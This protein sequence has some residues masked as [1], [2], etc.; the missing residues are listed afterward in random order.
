MKRF[1]LGVAAGSTVL[2]TYVTS[3]VSPST[4]LRTGQPQAP[5]GA[6][7]YKEFCGRC[8][9]TPQGRTP[10]LDALKAQS[11]RAILD[12]LNGGSMALQAQTLGPAEKARVAEY[13]AGRPLDPNT[14]TPSAGQCATRPDALPDPSTMPRW[15]G[16]GNDPTNARLQRDPGLTAADVPKLAVKW[17]FGFP[18]GAQAYGH[19]AIAAGRVFVGSDIGRVYALDAASGCTYWSFAADGGVRSAVSIGAIRDGNG[20][21]HA[22]YFGD[23][24]A[25]VYAVDAATGA[26]VWKTKVD[27]HRFARITGAPALHAGTLYIPVSSTEEGPGAQPA[28]PCCTF[29]GSIVALDA[30]TGSRIWKTY[31][32]PEEPKEV[33]KNAAGTPL[34]K[35]AGAAVWSSPTIDIARGVIYIGT[36]NAYT[37]PAAKTSDAVVALDMQKGTVVWVNQITPADAFVIGCRPENP[38]CPKEVGPDHDFGNAPIL[39]TLDGGKRII[40]IGQKSGVAYG[41]DPDRQGQIVWQF[42]AGKG[43]ALGGIEWGSA[44]DERAA[45]IPVSDVLLPPNEAG[46]LFALNLADGERLW[47]TPAPKLTCTSGRGCSGAQSAPISV[48]PGVVFSGSIDGHIRAYS[49]ADGTIIWDFNTA[50]EFETVNQVPAKGGSIDAAGPVIAGGLLI[51]NSGYG[52]WRGM[53]GNVLLAFSAK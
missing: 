2:T 36:G 43:S 46:G 40:V 45:Y 3:S 39:R 22:A 31:M 24:K 38:N 42:R 51:T 37:E 35:P 14:S 53:P 21:R 8:H 26:L 18:G 5:D 34:W 27:D 47:H 23:L 41:L 49:T 44:A 28:Y 50:R 10:A 11:A 52:L 19:P 48:I 15:S 20:P 4:S 17:A 1:L 16:W 32:I 12:A 6:A 33:G 30:A 7:V 13:L 9:D 25:N 29:R